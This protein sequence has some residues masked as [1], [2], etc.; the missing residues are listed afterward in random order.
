MT[1][2][3]S[4]ESVPSAPLAAPA[5]PPRAARFGIWFGC[6]GW[7]IGFVLV[8]FEFVPDLWLPLLGGALVTAS[9]A[10][11][12]ER[13]LLPRP[14]V[15]RV[16]SMTAAVCG[17]LWSYY[18]LAMMPAIRA[19]PELVGRLQSLSS[20]VEVPFWPGAVLFVGGVVG[21]LLTRPRRSA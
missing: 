1:T 12:A 2:A 8:G 4:V 16:W 19:L 21:L 5:A 20:V 15:P 18:A 6:F 10:W 17:V 13:V 11:S 3:R 7:L 14:A 9:V